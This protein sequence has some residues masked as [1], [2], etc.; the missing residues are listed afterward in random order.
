MKLSILSLCLIGISS[1]FGSCSPINEIKTLNYR[2]NTDIKPLD[3]IIEL[4]PYFDS[5]VNGNEPF[6]FDGICTIT[7]HA[8]KSNVDTITLHKQ[9]LK[10]L[11]QSLK[12]RSNSNSSFPQ[13]DED[14]DI[15][16]NDYNNITNI[17]TLKLAV[18][19]IKD[20][21]Y[22]LK[23]RYIGRLQTDMHG[24][25]RSSYQKGNVTK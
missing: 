24:L 21:L 6:T 15:K 19:L 2:L 23:F 11:E 20:E 16:S 18:P 3:Y 7:L 8:T 17:Y 14:I 1:D 4:T 12:M 9:D 5:S 22:V 25:Y 13:S 10:I